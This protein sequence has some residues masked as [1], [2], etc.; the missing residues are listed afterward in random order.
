MGLRMKTSLAGLT[1][2]LALAGAAAA[3]PQ[4]GRPAP[5]DPNAAGVKAVCGRCHGPERIFQAPLQ[6]WERWNAIFGQMVRL[7][8]K[9]SDAQIEQVQNYV[10][11]HLTVLNVNSGTAYELQ[12]VLHADDSVVQTIV[13]RRQEKPFKSLAE[14]RAVP[15]VDRDRLAALKDRITF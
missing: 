15:G 10:L 3:Q 6:S 11:D 12:W 13:S 9:G 4:A 5:D 7:G 14:L 8:A 1:F 2:G